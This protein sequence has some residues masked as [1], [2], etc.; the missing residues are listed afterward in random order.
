MKKH[1]ACL[2]SRAKQLQRQQSGI[3][4]QLAVLEDLLFSRDTWCSVL[5]VLRE[6]RSSSST[7]EQASTDDELLRLLG[8]LQP[9]SPDMIQQRMP[10]AASL[11]QIDRQVL[12]GACLAA[13]A[14]LRSPLHTHTQG[15][16]SAR[17]LCARSTP[18]QLPASARKG[19]G[20]LVVGVAVYSLAC[21]M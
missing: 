6:D 15:G 18:E 8:Q 7:R 1:I 12:T 2:Q 20:G 4:D 21:T 13:A 11:T 14:A 5:S 3:Q 17:H 16:L 9:V 10:M 19:I